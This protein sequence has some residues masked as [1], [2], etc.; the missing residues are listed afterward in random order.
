[1]TVQPLT[2]RELQ[3]IPMPGW[4]VK[5]MTSKYFIVEGSAHAIQKDLIQ[6]L[7][8]RQLHNINRLK[9]LFREFFERRFGENGDGDFSSRSMSD[10]EELFGPLIHKCES[11]NSGCMGR[12]GECTIKKHNE[13]KK[14]EEQ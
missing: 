1:M 10:L 11:G 3:F 13:A 12:C 5:E 9:E 7:G 8:Q 2:E 4:D 6:Y 14:M